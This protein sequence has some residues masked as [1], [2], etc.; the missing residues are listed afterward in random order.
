MKAFLYH[1]GSACSLMLLDYSSKS[2][3]VHGCLVSHTQVMHKG[4]HYKYLGFLVP[5]NSLILCELSKKHKV[6]TARPK[7]AV[8]M[9]LWEAY[10]LSKKYFKK[11]LSLQSMS[12]LCKKQW[13]CNSF[14]YNI[15]DIKQSFPR[16]SE[17]RLLFASLH[18]DLQQRIN[19]TSHYLKQFSVCL[20]RGVNFSSPFCVHISNQDFTD[21][22]Q[23]FTQS[24]SL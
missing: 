1:P 6:P 21:F 7:Q 5:L 17:Q 20:C 23:V 18:L 16:W 11:P 14:L 8:K 12:V 2:P 24:L 3:S 13:A 10:G 22:I 9:V 19:F 4:T 15:N